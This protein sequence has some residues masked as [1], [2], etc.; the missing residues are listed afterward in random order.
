[1]RLILEQRYL[2]DGS[3]AHVAHHHA[4]HG[5]IDAHEGTA[6][7][8]A[9][10]A[11]A[12][13]PPAAGI[14]RPEPGHTDDRQ[15][16]TLADGA[17][18]GS[19]TAI[20]FVDSRVADWK[21]LTA[22]LP[23]NVGVVVISPDRNGMDVVSRVL[24]H[25]QDL[26]SVNFL[27]YGQPGAAE[28]GNSTISE[29]T[30]AADSRQVT[31]WG[32]ALAPGGQILFW[33]CD[34]G[35][36]V[37]GRALV[38]D[39]HTLTGAD[40][41]ASTDRTGLATLGGNWT[42]EQTAGMDQA[43]VASPFSTQAEANYD[44]ALDGPVADVALSGQ[45]SALLGG[46]F[47]DTITFKNS[48][49]SPGYTPY[50][51]LFAPTN[52]KQYT[53]LESGGLSMVN[54]SGSTNLPYKMALLTTG[55]GNTIGATN[56]L[57]GTWVAAPTGFAVGDTMYVAQLPFG[58]YTPG[59]PPITIQATFLTDTSNESIVSRLS[60][61]GGLVNIA[62]AGGYALGDSP[63]GSTP[64]ASSFQTAGTSLDLLDV[65]SQIQTA[66]G[67][68]ESPT[69][70]D[71]VQHYQL[72]LTAAPITNGN[73]I[74]GGTVTIALP[75]QV[76][77]KGGT[78]DIGGQTVTPTFTG[79]PGKPGGTLNLALTNAMWATGAPLTIDIPVYVDRTDASDNPVLE[80]GSVVD[81]TTIAAPTESY[82][83]VTW[84]PPTGSF[85]KGYTKTFGA[86]VT[87]ADTAFDAKA[88]AIQE[89]ATDET[90]GGKVMPDDVITHTIAIE[91]SDF[92]ASN[93]LNLAATLS[94]GQ[95]ILGTTVPLFSYTDINGD[96]H[97][98]LSLGNA[99]GSTGSYWSYTRNSSTGVTTATFDIAQMLAA[100]DLPAMRAGSS[101]SLTYGSQAS[102]TFLVTS[103]PVTE[104]N[105]LTS[106]VN[107]SV[108]LLDPSSG[109]SLSETAGDTSGTTLAVAQGGPSLQ[110]VAINGDTGAAANPIKA[111]DY[112]TYQA[113]YNLTSNTF[114]GLDLASYLPLPLVNTADP[115][116]S[117]SAT[118]TQFTQATGQ[119][120]GTYI[121][122]AANQAGTYILDTTP[123]SAATD[124]TIAST[125]AVNSAANSVDFALLSNNTMSETGKTVTVLFT[126]RATDAPFADGLTMTSQEQSTFVYGSD[127]THDT[128]QTSVITQSTVA[129]PMAELKTGIVSVMTPDSHA[130][131]VSYTGSADPTAIFSAAGSTGN[132]FKTQP[133]PTSPD[134]TLGAIEDLDASQ[135]NA[136]DTVRIATSV[137]NSGSATMYGLTIA[138]TLPAGFAPGDVRNFQITYPD[139]SAVPLSDSTAYFTAA[140]LK[141]PASATES[142]L[143]AGQVLT[144]TYDL[145]L[146][147]TAIDTTLSPSAKIVNFWN[148]ADAAAAGTSTSGFVTSR[149]QTSDLGDG[150]DIT[151]IAPSITQSLGP[152]SI[153]LEDGTTVEQN[154]NGMD[155]AG[156]DHGSNT[157]VAG[158]QRQTTITVQVPQGTLTNAGDVSIT[159]TLPKGVTY[160]PG[161]QSVPGYSV[162]SPTPTSNGDGTT[163]LVFDLGSSVTNTN[164]NGTPKALTLTYTANY[165]NGMDSVGT[166]QPLTAALNYTPDGTGASRSL[167]ATPV[168]AIEQEPS[169]SEQIA[170]TLDNQKAAYS[171]ET[172]TY[173]ATI[174][175]TGLV[176]AYDVTV[177]PTNDTPTVLQGV[178]YSF[179]GQS[180][181]DTAGLNSAIKQYLGTTGLA[182][183][184]EHALT[185]QIIGKIASNQPATTTAK[186]EDTV[187]S[188][189]VPNGPG[190]T[191]YTAPEVQTATAH[192]ALVAV[193]APTAT[194]LS[195]VGEANDT[196]LVSGQPLSLARTG[197]AINVVPGDYV[198]LRG[199]A[200]LPEGSNGNVT[201]TFDVPSNLTVDMSATAANSN[202]KILLV[203]P[204][205]QMTST[206]LESL[207]G[208]GSSKSST[209]Q[210]IGGLSAA[211]TTAATQGLPLSADQISYADGKLTI[212]LGTVTDN[213]GQDNP[214]SVGTYGSAIYV[215]VDVNAWVNNDAS[216][217]AGNQLIG[218]TLSVS[219]D[220]TASQPVTTPSVTQTVVEPQV[221]L[222]KTVQG[223]TYDAGT[224]TY[225]VTYVDTLTNT[226]TVTAYGV[227]LND[228]FASGE[229][230]Y[231]TATLSNPTP[232]VDGTKNSSTPQLGSSAVTGRI[233]L[234]G[235]QSEAITY[236]VQLPASQLGAD[237]TTATVTWL[238]LQNVA[239]GANTS[240]AVDQSRDG[241]G[242]PAVDDYSASVTTGLAYVAGQVWQDLG[243][244]PNTYASATDTA[245]G[246]VK[247]KI[248]EAD[249]H[250]TYD[251]SSQLNAG[252]GLLTAAD[253]TY[254]TL[255]PFYGATPS[256]T[257]A[258]VTL[259]SAG[260]SG[261]PGGETLVYNPHGTTAAATATVSP[262]STGGHVATHV[263]MSFAL[264]DTAPTWAVSGATTGWG[265]TTP[266]TD[267]NGRQTISLGNAGT[268]AV[269]D[270]EIDRLVGDG[271]IVSA[272]AYAGTVL[273]VQRYS[274]PTTAS[275]S[276][277]D[278]FGAA[279]NATIANGAVSV[280]GTQIGT[281]DQAKLSTG[282]LQV[283]FGGNATAASI[284]T[285]L[286]NLTY[287][288]T[289]A[290]NDGWSNLA[291]GATLSDGNTTS[292]GGN[293]LTGH[294]G[295][296]GAKTSAPL[297]TYVDIPPASPAGFTTAFTEPNNN[298]PVL[299]TYLDNSLT[300][301]GTGSI[302]KAVIQVTNALPEDVL[303][304]PTLPSGISID[305]GNTSYDS[306]AYTYTLTLTGTVGTPLSSWQ[307][308]LRAITYAD[309]SDTPTTTPRN[310]TM[311]LYENGVATPVT[312]TGTVSVTAVDDSPVLTTTTLLPI[313]SSEDAA[314]PV[315]GVQ[316]TSLATLIGF[317]SNPSGPR[318]V[319]DPDLANDHDGSATGTLGIAITNVDTSKGT[320][321]YSTDGGTNWATMP[322][323]P[324]GSA[325][326]LT[327]TPQT[328]VY[329]QPTVANWN[330]TISNALTFRAWDQSDAVHSGTVTTLPTASLGQGTNTP[331][332]AYS[333]NAQSVSLNVAAVNDAPTI[334]GT[335]VMPAETVNSTTET[336]PGSTVASLFTSVFSDATDNATLSTANTLAGIAITGDAA[337]P[338][339]QGTWH[340][341]TDGG[342]NWTA[343]PSNLSATNALVLPT[344]AQLQFVPVAG[345]SGK[346]GGLTVHVVDNSG[347]SNN[348][349]PSFMK[350][351]T[352]VYGSDIGTTVYTGVDVSTAIAGTVPTDA[353]SISADS[354]VLTIPVYDAPTMTGAP[355][356][357]TE[358]ED[359]TAAN[360]PHATVTSV[361]GPVFSYPTRNSLPDPIGGMA[362]TGDAANAT[363]QGTWRYSTDGGA[364]WTVLPS[365]LSST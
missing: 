287:T 78:V 173:T 75:E 62:A 275:P 229:S 8:D 36:G 172:V 12:D 76:I 358:S 296:G 180:G 116:A 93:N 197:S 178:S 310:V 61:D 65:T 290:N 3:I 320:W 330:G 259:P 203:S 332:A 91:N 289:A 190:G 60:S 119:T 153:R 199:I 362:I 163:T 214:S 73:P 263:D 96:L 317:D 30:V 236:H 131:T 44:Y 302:Q 340:Y 14:S 106:S 128:Q 84:T 188:N 150:A 160:V 47:T 270:A 92:Y 265:G 363:T 353:A 288:Y 336:A 306:A 24:A 28:L 307:T 349:A 145:T 102:E 251:T 136:G 113:T 334:T 205:G 266:I 70:P 98:N 350:G 49:G 323:I 351:T 142:S 285:L 83:S 325:F 352:P 301:Q 34:V 94:D 40:I 201:L 269:S 77:F 297:W 146:P 346:P 187:T 198:T 255:I 313:Q 219:T 107:A 26:Q 192:D 258:T 71:Y 291:I 100:Q 298:T 207:L 226:S 154:Y 169:L 257:L 202:V 211:Q 51:E 183:G 237:A 45:A 13:A 355:Q 48:G 240:G 182:P 354:V 356:A 120:R 165:T 63:T 110:V 185:Y 282:I 124:V 235:G 194:S 204:D 341:S 195:I 220:A 244:T 72:T 181:L 276:A 15:A 250:G 223:I 140:G 21:E 95:T 111:G 233:T 82:A 166:D 10:E 345:F 109:Q 209:V 80:P 27:T 215:V 247:V 337:D 152:S 126:L 129:E 196:T 243:Y 248:V 138:G 208:T 335:P 68:D 38:D 213:A 42:L 43:Q 59:Q 5:G 69:G 174:T 79:T 23:D 67:E 17:A 357:P 254:A 149:T 85:D 319:Q 221:T 58:S 89:S 159:V 216:N 210:T 164:T 29:A 7:A 278:G 279:G 193:G 151:T 252:A 55:P 225:T 112:V 104:G 256:S 147:A 141:I 283:T 234:E 238:S 179:N 299:P 322:A 25:Q 200:T 186:V 284:A 343:L 171:G 272:N 249:G 222:T 242:N 303:A 176:H 11:V 121:G 277:T 143:A 218:E 127:P 137:Q 316:G 99:G 312:T 123:A 2:F 125:A 324:A 206:T 227:T 329:F 327:V 156:A 9:I 18:A 33:G 364:S 293:S 318:N 239:A 360:A 52:S 108:D 232:D 246:N 170:S 130:D 19:L 309:S 177:N 101:A 333:A 314:T 326:D 273:T 294:Q 114:D 133:T 260:Q 155:A 300:L 115:T 224:G 304:A 292:V 134:Q 144:V 311:S 175:N 132:I 280:G 347:Q 231:G 338:A 191:S 168:Q 286:Q 339:T 81:P 50:V 39:L 56:P 41:A 88:F 217:K 57:T 53:P 331:S 158:E 359:T 228:P 148:T 162:A 117:G 6:V 66:V 1:M 342:A 262:D 241:S 54:G 37:D 32:D 22:S 122:N 253:G 271:A 97:Q 157:V 212:N 315:S 87:S 90:G 321:Y 161:S 308:A 31:G 64:I 167:A 184:A 268:L 74:S 264:P 86:T 135:A 189:S 4:H 344:T 274:S 305:T 139:G 365:D 295:T 105:Q 261:L 46:T 348:A 267:Q 35:A 245:L 281:Y 20:V 118:T 361:L 16:A 103:L 328:Q 230:P